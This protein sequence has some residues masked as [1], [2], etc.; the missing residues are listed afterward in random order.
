MKIKVQFVDGKYPSVT[1]THEFNMILV[2]YCANPTIHV[3][4]QITTTTPANYEYTGYA[5][6]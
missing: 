5:D 2:D 3:P 4:S 1:D 6:F